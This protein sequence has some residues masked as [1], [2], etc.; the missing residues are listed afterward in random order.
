MNKYTAVQKHEAMKFFEEGFSAREIFE[1]LEIPIGTLHRWKSQAPKVQ[2]PVA[3]S[4]DLLQARVSTLENTVAA[5]KSYIDRLQLQESRRREQSEYE[6][7]QT[8]QVSAFLGK[9]ALN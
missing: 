4:D 8:R 5:L 9:K 6:S 3:D 7:G 1:V 2:Q